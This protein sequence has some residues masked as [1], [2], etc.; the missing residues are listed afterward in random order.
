MDTKLTLSIEM[1]VLTKAKVYAETKGQSLSALVENY[2]VLLTQSAETSASP[3]D[4]TP[5]VSSLKGSFHAPDDNDQTISK[6][7]KKKK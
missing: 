1:D 6:Q 7:Q 4:L 3:A 2:F 5:I